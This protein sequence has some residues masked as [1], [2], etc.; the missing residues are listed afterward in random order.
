MNYFCCSKFHFDYINIK[1]IYIY[2]YIYI[3]G[4]ETVG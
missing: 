3:Y 1:R 2:I 4:R